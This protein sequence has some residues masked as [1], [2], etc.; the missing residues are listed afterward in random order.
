VS[1]DEA[2]RR[3]VAKTLGRWPDQLDW[4]PLFD[5]DYPPEERLPRRLT[6]VFSERIVAGR[7]YVVQQLNGVNIGSR[8]TDN[9]RLPVSRRLPPRVRCGARLVT[10]IAGAPPAE[11]QEPT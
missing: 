4:G 11:A 2:A 10:D 1:L 7:P 3:N 5:V 9:R 8:L 6:M